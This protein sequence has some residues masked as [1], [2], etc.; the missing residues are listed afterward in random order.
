MKKI[1]LCFLLFKCVF[2][3]CKNEELYLE[4]TIAKSKIYLSIY[5]YGSD[6]EVPN[7]NAVYFYQ[8][9]LKD[10]NLEGTK[11][12]DIFTLIVKHGDTI[13]E[14]FI[15]KK[16]GTNFEGTWNNAQGK[17]FPVKLSPIDFTNYKSTLTDVYYID[18]K[19]DLIKL[20]FLEFKK[21]KTTFYK[22]KAIDWYSEKHCNVPFFRLG[23]NFTPNNKNKVNAVL[24]KIHIKNVIWQLDCSTDNNYN[25]GGGIS[26][27]TDFTFLN[28]NLL[29][30]KIFSDYYCGGAYPDTGTN[31]YLIDLNT[32]KNYEID[33]IIAFDKS[34]TTEKESNFDS[35]VKYRQKYFAPKLY[36][37]INNEQHFVKPKDTDE[38]SCDMTNLDIWWGDE[39]WIYTEKGIEF[40]PSFP[41]AMRACEETFLV[42]FEK[43]KKYKNPKFKYNL[44]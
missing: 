28:N 7:T 21:E 11:R 34:V 29:G 6:A 31:G 33:H 13:H 22:N 32:G 15:L 1:I 16:V 26:F 14:K 12:N 10:I 17:S 25:T 38:D 20:K 24:E 2:A 23:N 40:T 37:I 43:L 9:S 3:F 42:P 41:H 36:A 8:N 44:N 5:V 27:E 19:F 30:F 4:G 35:W 18:E 39:T